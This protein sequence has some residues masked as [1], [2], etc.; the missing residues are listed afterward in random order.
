MGRASQNRTKIVYPGI[1]ARRGPCGYPFTE[2]T[3]R[4][5]E[6]ISAQVALR[7]SRK[8][9]VSVRYVWERSTLSRCTSRARTMACAR[10][11]TSNLR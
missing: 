6:S 1:D 11:S 9:L 2:H 5:L 8:E 4:T 10:L 3:G 7:R